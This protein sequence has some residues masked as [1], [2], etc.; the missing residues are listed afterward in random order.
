M[1][2]KSPPRRTR[3]ETNYEA[4]ADLRYALRK[5]LAFSEAAAKAEDLSAQQHQALLAIKGTPEMS[6][7][8]SYGVSHRGCGGL[9]ES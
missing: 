9:Q 6:R 4:L 8:G 7:Y 2:G 5:F 1:A 3:E